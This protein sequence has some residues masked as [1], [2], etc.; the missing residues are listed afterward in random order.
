MAGQAIRTL[1]AVGG[2]SDLVLKESEKYITVTIMAQHLMPLGYTSF[3]KVNAHR[4][5]VGPLSICILVAETFR[6]RTDEQIIDSSQKQ[7]FMVLQ[8]VLFLMI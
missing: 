3:L 8:L 2:M 1:P 4:I 5:L 7:L 6:G